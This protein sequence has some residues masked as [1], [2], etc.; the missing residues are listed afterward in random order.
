[1]NRH[2]RRATAKQ[3]RPSIDPAAAGRLDL[4]IKYHQAGKLAEAEQCYRQVLAQHADHPDALQLMGVIASQAGRHD[5][6]AD[7]ITRAI[8]QNSGNAAWFSNLGLVR[9]RQGRFEEALANHNKALELKP[10]YA[11]AL[12]RKSVV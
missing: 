3:G 10:D 8:R 9:E 1:M 11:E 6:A 5:D 4:G 12:D 7:W 2:Q